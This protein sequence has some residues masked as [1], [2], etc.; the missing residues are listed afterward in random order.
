V[1]RIA[2]LVLFL[3]APDLRAVYGASITWTYTGH[4]SYVA[5]GINFPSPFSL[6][7]SA[8]ITFDPETPDTIP[9]PMAGEYFVSGGDTNLIVK[10]GDHTS[11]PIDRFEITTI[12]SEPNSAT[13]D[14]F[15]FHNFEG[16]DYLDIRFPG[17]I[18]NAQMALIF[19]SRLRP[20]P[21]TSDALPAEQPNPSDFVD[22]LLAVSKL[23][24]S[25]PFAWSFAASLDP[26]ASVPEPGS[27]FL[28][29][30]GFVLLYLHVR[31]TRWHTIHERGGQF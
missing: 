27:T 12:R 7:I 9:S 3:L 5:N 6:P 21:I 19:E 23:D 13:S 30:A 29:L 2:A 10:V 8:T 26:T 31:P 16:T 4:V 18:D 15:N 1:R 28:W 20:G 25:G 14:Q 22:A 11:T 17:Y 24:P